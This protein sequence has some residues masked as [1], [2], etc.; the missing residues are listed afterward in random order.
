MN[1]LG[2]V[3]GVIFRLIKKPYHFFFIPSI[4][5]VGHLDYDIFTLMKTSTTSTFLLMN[6]D[7]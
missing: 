4:N 5:E 1:V 3:D 2:H 6:E 7:T